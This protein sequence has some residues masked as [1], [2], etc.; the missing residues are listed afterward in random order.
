LAYFL[1]FRP[2]ALRDLRVF[3]LRCSHP[4]ASS[5]GTLRPF[6]PTSASCPS[7]CCFPTG[8]LCR[9][10]PHSKSTS[11]K[12]PA[13]SAFPDWIA[14]PLHPLRSVERTCLAL[15]K[16]R[17]QG[18]ATLSTMSAHPTLGSLLSA[19]NTLG[20][21]SPELSS[22]QMIPIAFPQPVPLLHFPK[23]PLSL[24]GV[25]QWLPPT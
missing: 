7:A 16:S 13:P 10:N 4:I 5:G 3:N 18:L 1:P 12:L 9:P 6:C 23:K 24:L 11:L 14:L 2:S 25:L 21:P 8:V 15:S 20:I 22:S 19:P 17:P